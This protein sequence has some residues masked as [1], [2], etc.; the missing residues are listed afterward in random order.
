M[1]RDPLDTTIR[2]GK[3]IGATWREA[4]DAGDYEYLRF[5]ATRGRK[6]P[7][8]TRVR[9]LAALEELG[10]APSPAPEEAPPNCVLP[11]GWRGANGSPST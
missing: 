2:F 9:L 6:A 11:E 4:L 8:R 5:I 10:E 1:P 3:W 7:K